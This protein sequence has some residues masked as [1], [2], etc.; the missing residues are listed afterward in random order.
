MRRMGVIIGMRSLL[1][2]T[3]IKSDNKLN[4]T[5]QNLVIDTRSMLHAADIKEK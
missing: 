4:T 3:I 2:S 5:F 1:K